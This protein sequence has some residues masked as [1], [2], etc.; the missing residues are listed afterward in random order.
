M[1][2]FFDTSALI[3]NYIEETGSEK[4]SALMEEAEEIFVSEITIIECF[5]TLKRILSERLIR[6]SD[7]LHLKDEIQYDFG[8]L[9]KVG[10]SPESCEQLI[11]KYQLK[12]LDSIQLAASLSV[13]DEIDTF[14]CCDKKLLKA[15]EA[16]NLETLNPIV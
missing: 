15:A 2:Y 12:S 14:I 3:K 5:S 4:V 9:S 10:I 13:S 1:N 7:Y 8:F 11:D 6:E 16:E